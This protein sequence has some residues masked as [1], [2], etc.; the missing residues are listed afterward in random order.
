MMFMV[1]IWIVLRNNFKEYCSTPQK[2]FHN[3]CTQ[4]ST[5]FCS[6]KIFIHGEKEICIQGYH[7][8]KAIW[9]AV[10]EDVEY[11]Q[12]TNQP[13]EL[14]CSSIC[15]I[16]YSGQS[17][18][19]ADIMTV[20]PFSFAFRLQEKFPDTFLPIS[21]GF[22]HYISFMT[23]TSLDLD[24]SMYQLCGPWALSLAA[25]VTAGKLTVERECLGCNSP[26]Q[27]LPKILQQCHDNHCSLTLILLTTDWKLWRWDTMPSLKDQVLDM[28]LINIL[29]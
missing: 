25:E 12:E 1:S 21:T 13:V 6:F 29:A 11:K 27:N 15:P 7:A 19:T 16:R 9:A 24:F 14:L 28:T 4:A 23:L 18:N 10:I 3:I 26:P 2:P 22:S 17:C 5:Q 20:F 8:Y